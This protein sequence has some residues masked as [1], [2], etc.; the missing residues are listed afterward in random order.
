MQYFHPNI[1]AAVLLTQISLKNSFISSFCFS[2]CPTAEYD[3]G[4]VGIIGVIGSQNFNQINVN[5]LRGSK[6]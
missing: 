5:D 1:A 6:G 4:G 2:L 3:G